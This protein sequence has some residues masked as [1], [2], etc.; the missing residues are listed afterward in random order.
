[1][2]RR[3]PTR[4][5]LLATAMLT[6][7]SSDA[8]A[9][10]CSRFW[11]PHSVP[12][13]GAVNVPTNVVIWVHFAPGSELLLRDASGSEVPLEM[14]NRRT[15][16]SCS[17]KAE[18]FPQSELLPNTEYALVAESPHPDDPPTSVSFTTGQ[19]PLESPELLAPEL[20]PIFFDASD[21]SDSCGA[22]GLNVCPGESQ[23]ELV[24][25][26]V[27]VDGVERDSNVFELREAAWLPLG[28]W[29][30]AVCVEFRTRGI[31]RHLSPPREYCFAAD[32]LPAPSSRQR[33]ESHGCDPDFVS[34]LMD[35]T[36]GPTDLVEPVEP[37]GFLGCASTG[38]RRGGAPGGWMLG[39]LLGALVG[40]R[41][42][43]CRSTSLR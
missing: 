2:I 43:V 17:E 13:H 19:G 21:F 41:R 33:P 29:E 38:S 20:S 3:L 42:W 14:Q 40:M 32:E 9:C 31:A 6:G 26:T 18:L 36:F 1:M 34:K 35:G 10:T 39:G 28:E 8:L 7:M 4:S 30:G 25:V 37:E 16:H 23:D 5:A 12:S 27:R 22:Y 11:T 15:F 24:E